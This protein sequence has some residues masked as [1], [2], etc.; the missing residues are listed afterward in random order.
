MFI[1]AFRLCLGPSPI[2]PFEMLD[3]PFLLSV[4]PPLLVGSGKVDMDFLDRNDKCKAD[5]EEDEG[6]EDDEKRNHADLSRSSCRHWQP[7]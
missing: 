2:H 3:V 4:I 7:A 5:E 6:G 1:T